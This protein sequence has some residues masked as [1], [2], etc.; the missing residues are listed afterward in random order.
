[1]QKRQ[2]TFQQADETTRPGGATRPDGWRHALWL[3]LVAAA[4]IAFSLGFACAV[5]FAAVGAIG[6]L[7]LDRRDALLL[8]AAVWLAN[9]LVGFT[10]LGYPWT[11]GTFGWGVALGVVAVLAALAAQSTARSLN[12]RG[13]IAVSVAAFAAAFV[14]YEGGLFVVAAGLL[15]GMEHFT[16]PI[17]T[18][19]LEINAAA[20]ALLFVLS[21]FAIAGGLAAKPVR[22]PAAIERHA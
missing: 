10:I 22:R 3:A 19:V 2:S 9:Q 5:P 11:A 20:F 16:A 7:T 18:R 12:G 17:V 1:M 13:T 6:A 21:R 15:G 4:S 8:A 14:L